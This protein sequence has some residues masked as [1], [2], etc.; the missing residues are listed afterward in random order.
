MPRSP[1]LLPGAQRCLNDSGRI[2][3]ETGPFLASRSSYSLLACNTLAVRRS[4]WVRKIILISI[5]TTT[6]KIQWSFLYGLDRA[7]G[8]NIEGCPAPMKLVVVTMVATITVVIC[9]KLVIY[10][11][12]SNVGLFCFHPRPSK[13]HLPKVLPP[14]VSNDILAKS[15]S[16]TWPSNATLAK[17]FET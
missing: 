9:Q 17:C 5:S 4:V 11:R 12:Y 13:A 16:Y 3:G 8:P 15:H 14:E 6:V 1:Q 2:G 10:L 7:L